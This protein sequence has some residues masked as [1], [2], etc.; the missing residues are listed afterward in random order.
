M[1]LMGAAL[2]NNRIILAQPRRSVWPHIGDVVSSVGAPL[3]KNSTCRDI[4]DCINRQYVRER[5]CVGVLLPDAVV[6]PRAVDPD[7]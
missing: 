3:V 7:A 4:F 5:N 6:V 1:G 2:S